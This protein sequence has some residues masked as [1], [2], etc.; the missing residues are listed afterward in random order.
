MS[1]RK[2]DGLIGPDRDIDV[3]VTAPEEIVEVMSEIHDALEARGIKCNG[4]CH[5]APRDPDWGDDLSE[6][7][8]RSSPHDIF[9]PDGLVNIVRIKLDT[10]VAEV[11]DNNEVCCWM[12]EE[13]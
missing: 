13:S 11:D 10:L 1:K 4:D 5:G 7:V 6:L 8:A 12:Y 9:D 3:D 2:V